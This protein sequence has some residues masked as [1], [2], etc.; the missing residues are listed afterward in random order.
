MALTELV[1]RAPAHLVED[2][3]DALVDELDA[4][5]VSWSGEE[6]VNLCSLIVALSVLM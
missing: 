4:V 2:V 1:L 3:S 6:R 5:S